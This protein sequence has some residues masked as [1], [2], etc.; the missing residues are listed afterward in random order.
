MTA[1]GKKVLG[2]PKI[3]DRLI[4]FD[5]SNTPK[6]IMEKLENFVSNP[7]FNAENAEHASIAA[8]GM[9][10]WVIAMVKYNTVQREIRP[11]ER[12]LNEAQKLCETLQIQLK[13]K[14]KELKAIQKQLNS[15]I[16]IKNQKENEREQILQAIIK[17]KQKILRAEKLIGGLGGEMQ[18]WTVTSRLLSSSLVNLVGDMILGSAF[19]TFLGPF[20][21]S[22]REVCM[23]RWQTLVTQQGVNTSENF[24]VMS[25]F[26][27]AVTIRE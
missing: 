17:N 10:N 16:D 25:M 14:K 11:K 22:Y 13:S 21:S 27:D 2:D 12:A 5:K 18:R 4:N 26:G 9:C 19:V 23:E 1:M 6:A 20:P 8:K 3:L 15:I 7:D 24:N